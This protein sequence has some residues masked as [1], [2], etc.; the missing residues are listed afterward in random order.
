MMTF[1]FWNIKG[2]PIQ[3][4]IGDV[5]EIYEVDVVILAECK[6]GE[7][8][9]LRELNRGTSR[10]SLAPPAIGKTLIYVKF[11][12]AWLKPMRDTLDLSIRHLENP[13]TQSKTIIVAAHL[14]SKS[15]YDSDVL[16]SIV[17][18]S[19]EEIENVEREVCH[20]NTIIVGDL[21]M[22]PFEKGVASFQGFQGVMDKKVARKGSRV[23]RGKRRGFFYNPMWS[24]MGDESCGPP[25]TFYY[26]D[27]SSFQNYYWN[28][29]DQVLL[30]PDLIPFFPDNELRIIT[31]I[32]SYSLVSDNGIPKS[33]TVSD[34]LPLL[35]RI[36][37]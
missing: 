17:T 35:F 6:I 3:E 12:T 13:I 28:T 19:R 16:E 33:N 1:L 37:I 32:N 25:G 26:N 15:H 2:N 24:L 21:N 4:I 23:M 31:E 18:E 30:R 22:N 9:L 14:P 8:D 36:D 5:V 34:H 20:M 29:L 7:I 27:S 11:P 10:F